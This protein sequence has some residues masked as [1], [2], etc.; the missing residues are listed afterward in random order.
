MPTGVHVTQGIFSRLLFASLL[1][2]MAGCATAP[3]QRA[4]SVP[5]APLPPV[6]Q[7]ALSL[8]GS[9]YRLGKASKIE[10]FDCSGLVQH[11]YERHGIMLPRTAQEMASVLPHTD[12]EN[13]RPGD[14]VFFD[15]SGGVY[16]HVGV[17]VGGDEFV[18]ASSRKS[19]KVMISHLNNP[20]WRKHFT[21]AR[22]TPL[23]GPH[24]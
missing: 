14:L 11:V 1:A 6:A 24:Q 7:Y 10:G 20:Y 9:P 21:G 17:L 15:T 16:S 18:H 22:R 5:P 4:I 23:T 19:G 3:D 12:L 2:M 8:L 13:L